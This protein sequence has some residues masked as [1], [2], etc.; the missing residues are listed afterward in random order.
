MKA[1]GGVL[2]AKQA[3]T[4]HPSP[5]SLP[6]GE[7]V[8]V[9]GGIAPALGLRAAA[10]IA[11]CRRLNERSNP[12]SRLNLFRWTAALA[13]ALALAPGTSS[14]QEP[15]TLSISGTFSMDYFV[16]RV[17]ADLA[18]VYS[19][20]SAHTWTLTLHGVSYSHDVASYTRLVNGDDYMGEYYEFVVER[21][22]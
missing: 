17:G 18:A 19:R 3:P 2:T 9:R 7:R 14:A 1:A 4:G 16:G 13:L 11:S 20:G 6:S 15:D 22:T 10:M 12:M 21:I 5:F 8:R